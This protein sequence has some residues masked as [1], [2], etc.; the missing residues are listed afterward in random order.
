LL[1]FLAADFMDHGWDLKRLIR[2]IVTSQTYRQSS[3]PDAV[4]LAKD[5]DNRLLS[6]QNRYRVDAE[7][8]RDIA[9]QVSG[10]LKERFGGPSVRPY[11]PRGYL[12]AL[13][14]PKRDYSESH[15]DDLYRRGLY[16]FW[17]RTFLHPSLAAFDAPAREECVIQRSAS[18]TPL[19]SLVLLNDPIYVE[20]AR[21][22][23]ARMAAQPG[24]DAR[25]TF[26]FQQALT[27]APTPAERVV[28]RELY[29]SE[30]TRF[31]KTSGAAAELLAVGESKQPVATPEMAALTSVAR[32]VLNLHEA[33]TR[34]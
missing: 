2:Q 15:G 21:T 18:N 24:L 11:Q 13:N 25:L 27:R 28:L 4:R 10:L 32:A 23:A 8:V 5:P 30:L 34:N 33:I 16:T 17:Q 22:F 7:A 20:A 9:L 26:A 19:Q 3:V 14:F 31:T 6:R 1:D 29:Q 12:A